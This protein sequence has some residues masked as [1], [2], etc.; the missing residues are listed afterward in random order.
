MVGDC[1]GVRHR[2]VTS[3][4]SILPMLPI[5]RML[6]GPNPTYWRPTIS[7]RVDDGPY[8]APPGEPAVSGWKVGLMRQNENL[9]PHRRSPRNITAGAGLG[10][11]LLPN[12]TCHHHKS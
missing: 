9:K 6:G 11:G 10:L 5:L 12:S 3:P 4:L 7:E 8:R 1:G 2:E